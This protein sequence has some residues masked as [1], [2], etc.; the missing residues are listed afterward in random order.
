[1]DDSLQKII[2]FSELLHAFERTERAVRVPGTE[3]LEND[4]EH[5]YTLATLAWYLIETLNLSLNKEKVFEYALAHDMPEVYAG[6]TPA[7][8]RGG[9]AVSDTR[10]TKKEREEKALAILKERFPEFPSF[11]ETIERYEEQKDDES[12][13]VYALDKLMPMFG[14][15]AQEGR[16]WKENSISF[17]DIATYKIDKIKSHPEIYK[18]FEG[19]MTLLEK[20]QKRF[21]NP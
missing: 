1:M 20:D 15:Y 4:A 16:D 6:D 9:N 13:F 18:I 2:T 10:P 21:F 12:K 14:G 8:G 7:F 11:T 17:E 19:L 5:S 3:R